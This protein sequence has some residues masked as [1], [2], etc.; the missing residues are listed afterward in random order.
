MRKIKVGYQKHK[1]R[2][3]RNG[4]KELQREKKRDCEVKRGW[5]PSQKNGN[6]LGVGK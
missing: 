4:H 3:R 1:N 6:R 2:A 5:C